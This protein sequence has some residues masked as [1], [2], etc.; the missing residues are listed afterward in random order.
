M[1]EL[2]SIEIGWDEACVTYETEEGILQEIILLEEEPYD[3][4]EV[5]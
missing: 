5:L 2:N 3:E 4:E 1:K